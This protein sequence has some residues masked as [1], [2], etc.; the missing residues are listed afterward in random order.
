[1]EQYKTGEKAT[2]YIGSDAYVVTVVKVTAKSVTV[3]R[4]FRDET[5]TLRWRAGKFRN[6]H[7]RLGK[8]EHARLDP[9]F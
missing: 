6:S 4:A 8:G 5:M 9:H 7:Y 2:L 1:M 3:M